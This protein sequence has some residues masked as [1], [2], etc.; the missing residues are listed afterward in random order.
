MST[1]RTWNSF[2]THLQREGMKEFNKGWEN[3]KVMVASE[4]C[5]HILTEDS[6]IVLPMKEVNKF[7]QC[8][9]S[10]TR[11]TQKLH[12]QINLKQ[13]YLFGQIIFRTML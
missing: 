12:S 2:G 3:L 8:N 4:R 7:A 13:C 5:R 6:C 9:C 1:L 11:F 10:L